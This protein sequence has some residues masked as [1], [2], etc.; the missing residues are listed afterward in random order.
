MAIVGLVSDRAFA[1]PLQFSESVAA[2]AASSVVRIPRDSRPSV[3]IVT[4][5]ATGR[6][7]EYTTSPD[8]DVVAG[9]AIWRTWPKGTVTS[10]TPAADTEAVLAGPVTALRL[11]NVGGAGGA[12]TW[13]VVG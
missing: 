12:V 5:D 11:D 7:V 8:E 10:A 6:A 13:E 4:A 9:T 1:K 2:T 3:A